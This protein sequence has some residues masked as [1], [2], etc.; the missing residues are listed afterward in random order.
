M[1]KLNQPE[2]VQ[3]TAGGWLKTKQLIS[4]F[5]IQNLQ[6]ISF[7]GIKKKVIVLNI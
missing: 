6:K 4:V 5:K 1:L 7:F 3:S 2:K